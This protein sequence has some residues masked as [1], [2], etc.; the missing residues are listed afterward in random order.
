[1]FGEEAKDRTHISPKW[2][3]KFIRAIQTILNATKGIVAPGRSFFNIAFGKNIEEFREILY[4]PEPY[5][6][7]RSYFE[8]LGL[9]HQWRILFSS[10]SDDERNE[11]LPIIHSNNFD[12]LDDSFTPKVKGLLAH[13]QLKKKTVEQRIAQ[14]TVQK[15]KREFNKLIKED[16]FIEL[17]LTYDF[18][19]RHST[20]KLE[21]A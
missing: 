6:L 1:L 16:K 11:I 4:M 8:K 7:F 5:I 19:S 3:R 13:Y 18:E 10:L 14:P 9:T 20:K 17:T 2:N 12:A 21:I 15:L